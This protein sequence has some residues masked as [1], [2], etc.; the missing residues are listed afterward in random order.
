[1]PWTAGTE[2]AVPLLMPVLQ[3]LSRDGSPVSFL[4]THLSHCYKGVSETGDSILRALGLG[5]LAIEQ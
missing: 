5:Q 2:F 4:R 1:M 3:S